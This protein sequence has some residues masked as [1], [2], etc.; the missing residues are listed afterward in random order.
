MIDGSIYDELMIAIY[1]H[2]NFSVGFKGNLA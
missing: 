2:R 1:M